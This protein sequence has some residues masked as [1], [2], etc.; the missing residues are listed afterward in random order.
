MRGMSRAGSGEMFR[1]NDVTEGT[2]PL[3]TIL[4]EMM[5]GSTLETPMV[6]KES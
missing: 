3:E 5:A 2:L 1:G 6:V 4:F